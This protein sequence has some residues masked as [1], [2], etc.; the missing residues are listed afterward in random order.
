MGKHGAHNLSQTDSL[1]DPILHQLHHL[2]YT[3]KE[4]STFTII[5]L[6]HKRQMI[7]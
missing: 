2:H 5:V 6:K 4:N 3:W 1:I 7:D